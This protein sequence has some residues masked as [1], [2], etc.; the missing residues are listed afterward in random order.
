MTGQRYGRLVAVADSGER[1]TKGTVMWDCVCDCGGQ[2]RVAR[3]N[4]LIGSVQ[5]C[6]CLA[7]E[8]SAERRRASKLPPVPCRVD[9]CEGHTAKGGDG[10]C[11]MHYQ[12][13]VRYGDPAYVTPEDERRARQRASLMQNMKPPAP[14]T[15][16]KL[17]GKHEHRR[18]GEMIAGRTL[19]PDEHVHHIDGDK[20]NNSPDNLMVLD[21]EEHLRLHALE[22][23]AR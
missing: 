11:G 8:L 6:G 19:R 18:I 3:G 16:K 7:R 15:Y 13:V 9:G 1:N 4:L 2:T 21:R 14:H 12:R 10:Y 20:H 23:A 5:S 17:N 22:R